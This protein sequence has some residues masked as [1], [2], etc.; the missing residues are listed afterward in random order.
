[1][2]ATSRQSIKF[3]DVYDL[4]IH[5]IIQILITSLYGIIKTIKQLLMLKIESFDISLRLML[6]DIHLGNCLY[7]LTQEAKSQKSI[8]IFVYFIIITL[9]NT[10]HTGLA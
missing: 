3:Q 1:M 7:T 4:S 6:I 10:F 9:H 2:Y 8:L 5:Q